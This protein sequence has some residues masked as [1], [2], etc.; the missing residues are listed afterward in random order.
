MNILRKPDK[1]QLQNEQESFFLGEKEGVSVDFALVSDCMDVVLS[2][3][4]P[5]SFVKLRWYE[6]I[7]YDVRVYGDAVERGYGDL[8]FRGI[9]P[10]RLMAWYT[11]LSREN[12]KVGCG[13]K[14]RPNA[15]CFWQVDQE[16]VTLWLDVRCGTKD[17]KLDG[18]LNL[19]SIVF[20]K[21]DTADTFGFMKKFCDEMGDSALIPEEPVYGSNNWYY[22]YG[23]SSHEQ[24]I[25]DTRLLCDL[26][27]G[28]ENRPYMVIDDGWQLGSTCGQCTG[29]LGCKTNEKFPD[30][31]K[32]ADEIKNLG[33]KPG[34]WLRPLKF[35][36]E[37]KCPELASALDDTYIDPSCPEALEKIAADVEKVTSQWGY[38]L[39][40][41]DFATFDIFC[42]MQQSVSL[43][44]AREEFAF[45][46]NMT[47]AQVVKGFYK[48]VFEHSN[49]AVIIGCNC[50]GH[51]GAGY[52][53]IHRSGDDT[54]GFFWERT[55]KYGINTLAYRLPQHKA[56]FDVDADCVGILGENIDWKLNSAWLELLSMSG[57]PLFV[58]A[59]PEALDDEKKSAIQA[60]FK[61]ASE[62]NDD[63][64]PAELF[65]ATPCNWIIN[66]EEKEFSF[67]DVMG[68]DRF[69]V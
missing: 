50:I 45:R 16:G 23:N 63:L 8:G 14:V 56:F 46:H 38:R 29:T 5:I 49:G 19:A 30:M 17:F 12:G 25:S 31:K 35:S 33:A 13:V 43:D 55:R 58:S 9:T 59:Q 52:F 7:P 21:D 3:K 64:R 39:I 47:S 68:A 24:I 67:S 20:M 4:A 10:E 18:S 66:G 69:G 61:R 1:I 60:A 48:T 34:L 65:T 53:H 62:Q 37:G 57:T 28:L 26:T 54:S 11:V 40:K 44:M 32:L 22:S 41:F 27:S 15:F 42:K 51:L 36:P 6:K 2:G